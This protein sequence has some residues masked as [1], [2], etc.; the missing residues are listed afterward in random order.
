MDAEGKILDRVEPGGSLDFPMMTGLEQDVEDAR[1]CGEGRDLQQALSLLRVLQADPVLGSVSEV[2]IDRSEGLSFVLE[3]FPVPVHMGWSGFLEKM[4][5]FEKA[6]PSLASQLNGI[7]RV[8][9][10]FSGQIV[11]KQRDGGKVRV[12]RRDGTETLAGSDPSLHPT[13]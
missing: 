1:L 2:Q 10:R 9:L 3:A 5:R 12:P 13:T 8:D 7:E 11:L 4:I 6:L